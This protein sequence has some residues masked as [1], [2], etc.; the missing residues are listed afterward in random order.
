M[1]HTSLSSGIVPSFFKIAAIT[2]ILKKPGADP[3]NLDN[4]RPISNLPFISKI[5]EKA[6]AAQVQDHL[7]NNNLYECFQS[8]FRSKHS[9]ET[10]LVRVTNDLLMAADGGF[11]SSL[12]LLD[13]ST[14]FDTISHNI[15]LNC[16]SA[17]GISGIPLAWFTSYLSNR[18]Q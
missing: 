3:N 18:T 13:L 8:G 9:T 17:I 4:F 12:V 7:S 16:L 10:A 5:L 15:L 2:P 6:V 14:A 11:L 1:V